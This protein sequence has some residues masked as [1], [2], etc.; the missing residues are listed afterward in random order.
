M[1]I[2]FDD[3]ADLTHQGERIKIDTQDKFDA[4]LE[5]MTAYYRYYAIAWT[6]D[7]DQQLEQRVRNGKDLYE[8][9]RAF[10]QDLQKRH[11][12]TL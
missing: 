1:A 11:Q 2:N 10:G 5:M 6:S 4:T 8:V 7:D 9:Q 3:P 12:V